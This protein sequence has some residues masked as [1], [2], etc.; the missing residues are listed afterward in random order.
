MTTE[1][2]KE[3]TARVKKIVGSY[4]FKIENYSGLNSAIGISTESP[5]F[6]STIYIYIYYIV[7]H[8]SISNICIHTHV[9]L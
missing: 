2:H 1:E 4:S 7:I 5:E 6:V 8:T 3:S 9:A